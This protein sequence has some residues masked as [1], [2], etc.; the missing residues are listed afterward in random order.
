[1]NPGGDYGK[2][3][4]GSLL[5]LVANIFFC[6]GVLPTHNPRG[7]FSFL[8]YFVVAH[9]FFG[10]N[11]SFT[12]RFWRKNQPTYYRP[13][14]YYFASSSNLA[15]RTLDLITSQQLLRLHISGKNSSGPHNHSQSA[16]GTLVKRFYGPDLLFVLC[17]S[18]LHY[19]IE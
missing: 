16:Y 8:A 19:A 1:M 9:S 2:K 12:S 18:L 10:R 6:R 5:Y 3:E 4:V 7:I 13:F 15:P 17:S 14:I 11:T